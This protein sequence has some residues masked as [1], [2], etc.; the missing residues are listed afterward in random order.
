MKEHLQDFLE[1]IEPFQELWRSARLVAY[2]VKAQNRW[3]LVSG[4]LQLSEKSIISDTFE[5][6]ADF[7]T[8]FAFIN[9]FQSES[10]EHVLGEI[11]DTE[12]IHLSLGHPQSFRDI[13]LCSESDRNQSWSG[14]SWFG[15][16]KFDRTT[17]MRFFQIDRSGY[18]WAAQ[19]QRQI[20][21]NPELS[22]C[23]RQANEQLS[24]D[25]HIDG[26]EA[27][28]AKYTP[29]LAL[30]TNVNP[31]F[32][33]IAPLPFD[34]HYTQESGVSLT[35][36][37]TVHSMPLLK[38][39][40]YPGHQPPAERFARPKECERE[41]PVFHT[42]WELEWPA[43]ATHAKVHLFYKQHNIDTLLVNRWSASASTRGAV[44]EYFD[45]A[46]TRLRDALKWND[47]KKSDEFELAVV[48][49]LNLLGIP[50]IWYG[51]AVDPDRADAAALIQSEL[52]N[53]LM[54][55]ECVR[56]KP[57]EKFSGLAERAR[58]IAEKLQI[59]NVLPLVFTPAQTVQTEHDQAALYGVSLVGANEIDELLRLVS[60]PDMTVGKVIQ[61]LRIERSVADIISD[62][63]AGLAQSY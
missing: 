7:S 62:A 16:N 43:T 50:A 37:V 58:H 46:H 40:F 48:R 20:A 54:L 61:Y 24:R 51:K 59:E 39:F 22:D 6:V 57:D 33:I 52:L 27:L 26:L 38:A 11:V 60:S 4:R 21:T 45:S 29:G 47:R 17:G 35:S 36:P 8:F 49:L 53:L 30:S 9:E 56:E 10:I 55:I 44:D 63:A 1:Q 5:K 12:N 42:E 19:S 28:S 32:Q 41:S 18:K 14:L 34:F 31:E 2:A 23:L 25:T 3:I 13:G 15:P